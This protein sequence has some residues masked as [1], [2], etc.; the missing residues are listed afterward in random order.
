MKKIFLYK[1]WNFLILLNNLVFLGF[2]VYTKKIMFLRFDINNYFFWVYAKK[3]KIQ[4]KKIW[5]L[6][7]KFN[8]GL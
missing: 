7:K 6:K 2:F 4:N 1:K 5:G 3:L 8:W